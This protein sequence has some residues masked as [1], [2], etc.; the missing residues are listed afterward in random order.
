MRSLVENI[1]KCNMVFTEERR[2][3][4][5]IEKNKQDIL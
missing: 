1:R 5:A 3:G 4:L 2:N